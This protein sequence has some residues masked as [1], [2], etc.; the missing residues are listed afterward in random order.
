MVILL[1]IFLMTGNVEDFSCV[2]CY[3]YVFFEKENVSGS[4]HSFQSVVHFLMLS[5]MSFIY[6]GYLPCI[7]DSFANIFSHSL[8]SPLHCVNC[9]FHSAKVF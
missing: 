1:C 6:L 3:L 8:G 5:Y 7:R 9:F 2:C 4:L